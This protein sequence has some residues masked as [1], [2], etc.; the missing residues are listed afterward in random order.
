MSTT[1]DTV[2]GV[3]FCPKQL[4]HLMHKILAP[5]AAR[6]WRSSSWQCSARSRGAVQSPLTTSLAACGALAGMRPRQGAA[7]T[8]AGRAVHS[9]DD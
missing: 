4:C 9:G 3:P 1:Q 6:A 8:T 7:Q 5:T 2:T